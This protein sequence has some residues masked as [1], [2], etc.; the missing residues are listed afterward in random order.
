MDFPSSSGENLPSQVAQIPPEHYSY[1]QTTSPA[2]NIFTGPLTECMSQQQQPLGGV[3]TDPPTGEATSEE[4]STA[5]NLPVSPPA[6]EISSGGYHSVENSTKSP[7]MTEDSSTIPADEGISNDTSSIELSDN[8][9]S[10][11]HGRAH[12]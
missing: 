10:Q 7:R 6:L 12:I 8:I 3:Q 9:Y 11:Q 4:P 1:S 5:E 2:S